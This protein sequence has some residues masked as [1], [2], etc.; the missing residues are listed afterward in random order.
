[1]N[2]IIL[3]Q[4]A[5]QHRADLRRDVARLAAARTPGPTGPAGPGAGLRRRAGWALVHLG[6][7]LA[8]RS[9]DA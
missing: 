9:A 6:L 2:P 8:V 7:R 4:M 1:M 3:D 5:H